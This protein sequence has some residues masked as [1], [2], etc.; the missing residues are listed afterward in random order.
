MLE[1]SLLF[2]FIATLIRTNTT[3]DHSQKAEKYALWISV[4]EKMNSESIAFRF[5][6]QQR[7]AT[8][9]KALADRTQEKQ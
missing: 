7:I 2:H 4:H 1:H 6:W 9:S 5:Q 8:G 3:L